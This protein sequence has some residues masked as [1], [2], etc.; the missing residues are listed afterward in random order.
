MPMKNPSDTVGNRTRDLR[1]CSAVPQPATPTMVSGKCLNTT[2]YVHCLSVPNLI[3]LGL[4]NIS[5]VQL[6]LWQ[7]CNT[8]S[9]VSSS[10]VVT[11]ISRS[12]RH[13]SLYDVC[14]VYGSLS[15]TTDVTP[16][17][18]SIR[19]NNDHF[20][21]LQRYQQQHNHPYHHL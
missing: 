19:N 8:Q 10:G 2:L 6:R 18:V 4:C 12:K 1:S 3:C 17:A 7:H 5:D 13:E 11:F 14:A 20:C 21:V 15:L 9:D 16:F